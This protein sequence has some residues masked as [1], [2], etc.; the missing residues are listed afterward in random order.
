MK[1][2][3]LKTN[4]RDARMMKKANALL[5]Y[6]PEVMD[7]NIDFEDRDKVL[8]IEAEDNLEETQVL[9]IINTWGIKCEALPG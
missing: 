2:F 9:E 7:W 5:A 4:I 1:L 8:R 3:I 6:S